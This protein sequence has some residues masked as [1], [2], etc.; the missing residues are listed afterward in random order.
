MY[1]K[2]ILTI[3]INIKS[4]FHHTSCLCR[5]YSG[6]KLHGPK[7]LASARA[8]LLS[9]TWRQYA[10]NAL[11]AGLSQKIE[12]RLLYKLIECSHKSQFSRMLSNNVES[13]CA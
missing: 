3:K 5:A 8:A 4:L 7:P 13:N 1:D 2:T 10:Q 11:D 12:G 9:L 6:A